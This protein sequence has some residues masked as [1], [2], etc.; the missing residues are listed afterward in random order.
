VRTGLIGVLEVKTNTNTPSK[1]QLTCRISKNDL[2]VGWIS[3]ESSES[4][5]VFQARRL[6]R[7]CA[8][9]LDMAAIIAPLVHGE[10]V[11]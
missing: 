9:S 6:A 3:S 5:R 1:A 4:L 10:I 2:A 11:Q 8:I 7:A